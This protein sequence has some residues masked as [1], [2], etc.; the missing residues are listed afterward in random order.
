MSL[1]LEA[2]GRTEALLGIDDGRGRGSTL[3]L[4][5]RHSEI[6]LL[7]ASA[8][9]GLSGDELAVLL[10][11]EDNTASTLRAELNR[12]RNLLGDD[13]LASRPYRLV[14][15]ARRRLARRAGEGARG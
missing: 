3:R 6:L 9:Q 15:G 11:E 13:V 12:L 14:G 7:L 5:P 8:P 2:L 1:R 10:Y 4:R